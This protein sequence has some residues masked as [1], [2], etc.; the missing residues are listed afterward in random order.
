MGKNNMTQLRRKLLL[1]SS[2]MNNTLWVLILTKDIQKPTADMQRQKPTADM[3]LH[4]S[5]E[6]RSLGTVKRATLTPASGTLPH[7]HMYLYS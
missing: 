2:V 5:A 7:Q 1:Q 3:Q 6:A 4:F